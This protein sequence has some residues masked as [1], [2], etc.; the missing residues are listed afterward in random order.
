MQED[1]HISEE[2]PEGA[3][4]SSLNEDSSDIVGEILEG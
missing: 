4:S 2:Q 1:E 3:N